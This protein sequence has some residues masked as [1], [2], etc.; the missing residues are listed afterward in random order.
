MPLNTQIIRNDKPLV[1]SWGGFH[2]TAMVYAIAFE[3]DLLMPNDIESYPEKA[4]GISPTNV[5]ETTS[6]PVIEHVC[7]TGEHTLEK[8]HHFVDLM[9]GEEFTFEPGDRLTFYRSH[10]G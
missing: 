5:F 10:K 2:V 7:P 8:Q 4:Q 1:V 3:R 9:D 6:Y